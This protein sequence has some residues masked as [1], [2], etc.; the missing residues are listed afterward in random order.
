MKHIIVCGL[1]YGH[2]EMVWP[3]EVMQCWACRGRGFRTVVVPMPQPTVRAAVRALQPSQAP[4][5]VETT[6][7]APRA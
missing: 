2:G 4:G 7:H 3:D 1:C 6:S 5:T